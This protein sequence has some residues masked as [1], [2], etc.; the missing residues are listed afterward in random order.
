MLDTIVYIGRFS[1]CHK[2]HIETIAKACA[3]AKQVI[4]LVGSSGEPRTIRNPFTF[5]ERRLMIHESLS[6]AFSRKVNIE[7]LYNYTYNDAKW[8]LQVQQTV[9]K[10]STSTNIG[11]IGHSK[12]ETS[13]YLTMFP[14]WKMIEMEHIDGLN[15]S[16]IRAEYFMDGVVKVPSMLPAV[17][18]FLT[19]FADTG[20]YTKLVLEYDFQL[21]HDEMWSASPYTP[22]FNTTDAV[23]VQSGHVLLIQR[24]NAPGKGLYALPGGYLNPNETLIDCMLRELR[25]ET[26]IKVP[27]KVLRGSI[28]KSKTYDDPKRSIRGRIITEAFHVQL[29]NVGTLPKVRGAD[30]ADKAKWVPLSEFFKMRGQMF[31]DHYHIIID[32]LGL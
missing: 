20:D 30:D 17:T 14:Q 32:L 27:E 11:L 10:L 12:D 25:E 29:S 21:K 31:E 4:V 2:G 7:P 19:K 28:V 23:V 3:L 8:E 6:P 22:T 5:P 15:A 9:D 13:Y 24:K 18:R 16:D 26:K 1:P